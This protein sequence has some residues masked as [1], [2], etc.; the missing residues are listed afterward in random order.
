MDA[1]EGLRVRFIDESELRVADAELR[2][3][4]NVNT[5]G[6]LAAARDAAAGGKP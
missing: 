3:F 6:E 5:P 4:V 2:S 1:L